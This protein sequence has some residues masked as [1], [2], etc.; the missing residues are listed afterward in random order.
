MK[1]VAPET[2][3]PRAPAPNVLIG[4]AGIVG[5]SLAL[6]LHRQGA[7]VLVLEQGTAFEGASRAAAGMLAAE[8]PYNPPPLLPLSRYSLTLY[9]E[10]LARIEALSGRPVPLQTERTVQYTGSSVYPLREHSVDPRQL[11]PAL[12]QAVRSASIPIAEH[13]SV[14]ACKP[15]GQGV[16][17]QTG[18]GERFQAGHFV[19]TTGAWALPGRAGA[20]IPRKGQMLRVRMPPHAPLREVHRAEHVYVVP[21]TAGP[22]A[23]TALIGATVEDAGFDLSTHP[24][25]LQQLRNAAAQLSPDLAFTADAP[26][27]E[28]WAGL[29]PATPDLLPLLGP[30]S[31]RHPHC[32]IAAGHFRNGI[33]LAP[34]TAVLLADLLAG[35]APAVDLAPFAPGR[36]PDRP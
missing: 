3:L 6:E 20:L 9:P 13:T 14:A 21:R 15:L 36:F 4:G 10:F 35:R 25:Q 12:L 22:H 11:G 8:D 19:Q 29:R 32:W 1:F 7:S 23:A 5:L 31:A 26:L 18:R 24:A 30:W 16:E 2:H 17:V 28:A 34:A 27:L 33:L